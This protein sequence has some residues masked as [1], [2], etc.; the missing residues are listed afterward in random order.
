MNKALVFTLTA[1]S[2]LSFPGNALAQRKDPS[3]RTQRIATSSAK[4]MENKCDAI[5]SRISAY[6]NSLKVRKDNHSE[7]Y[8]K[9]LQR[10]TKLADRLTNQGY[11]TAIFKSHLVT[12]STM[13]EKLATYYSKFI[14]DTE[15]SLSF[16]CMSQVPDFKT[17]LNTSRQSLTTFQTQAKEILTPRN[18]CLANNP[19]GID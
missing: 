19:S 5:E 17:Q 2:I 11:D 13:I 6:L 4:R 9:A 15:T 12:L 14:S 1:L 7:T 3:L 16:D 8:N 18:S 10:W